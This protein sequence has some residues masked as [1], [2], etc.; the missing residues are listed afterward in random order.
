MIGVKAA[1][2]FIGKNFATASAGFNTS[3]AQYRSYIDTAINLGHKIILI[4]QGTGCLYANKLY[5]DTASKQ[6]I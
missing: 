5:Q 6:N 2:F 4:G 1:K 3:L